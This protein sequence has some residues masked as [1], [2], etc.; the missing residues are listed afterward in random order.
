MRDLVFDING[1]VLSKSP[2]CDFSGIVRGSRG[3]LRCKFN[4]SNDWNGY[5][6]AI[7][8]QTKDDNEFF[9]MNGNTI[10]VPDKIANSWYFKIK[11]YA[12]ESKSPVFPTNTVMVKQRGD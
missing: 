1:Q 5:D 4:F 9:L 6:K 7:E 3:Y 2:T 11:L 10:F 12:V 8:F